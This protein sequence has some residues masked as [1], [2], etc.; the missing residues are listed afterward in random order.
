MPNTLVTPSLMVDRTL[1]DW[2]GLIN[3]LPEQHRLFFV[4]ELA[5]LSKSLADTLVDL[6][7]VHPDKEARSA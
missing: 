4:Q 1:Q 3:A 5:S 7:V 6:G 2:V